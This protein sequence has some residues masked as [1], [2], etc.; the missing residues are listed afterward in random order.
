[1]SSHGQADEPIGV[2]QPAPGYGRPLFTRADR[3]WIISRE[4]EPAPDVGQVFTK[5]SRIIAIRI[6]GPFEVET[7]HGR[8]GCQDGWLVTNHPDDGD[9]TG[10]VWPISAERMAATYAPA[11]EVVEAAG[12]VHGHDEGLEH[13]WTG[14]RFS[15]NELV[16]FLTG[17]FAI[18]T[19]TAR[20]RVQ[21]LA[22]EHPI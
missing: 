4:Q 7:E 17:T 1:M 13:Y 6:D 9:L 19:E 5:S 3:S 8:V 15:I 21:A 10:D 11:V 20:L 2:N 18:D 16:T 12:H 14:R 22:E